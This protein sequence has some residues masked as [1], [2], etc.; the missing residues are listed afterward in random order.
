MRKSKQIKNS[1]KEIIDSLT[2]LEEEYK[3]EVEKEKERLK[4]AKDKIEV[5]C[6]EYG[7]FAG[8]LLDS[9][10][11]SQI[12]KLAIETKEPVSIPFEL[13]WI[14]DLNR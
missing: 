4:E 7:V 1:S 14:D 12:V 13:Y 3:S 9:V 10:N 5:V 2:K 11:L 6:K 8:A